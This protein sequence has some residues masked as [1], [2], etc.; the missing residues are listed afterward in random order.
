MAGTRTHTFTGT[1]LHRGIEEEN[2]WAAFVS[3]KDENDK[4]QN[5]LHIHWV[6]LDLCYICDKIVEIG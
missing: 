2:R 6:T 5:L 3:W 1:H 4:H